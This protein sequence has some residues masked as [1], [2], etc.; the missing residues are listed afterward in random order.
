MD[1]TLVLGAAAAVNRFVAFVKVYVD[2]LGL[3]DKTRDAVLVLIAV[4]AG[5]LIA[6][7]APAI[8]IFTNIPTLPL[9]AGQI[10]TGAIAG[11]GADFLNGVL[12]LLYWQT[13]PAN[14]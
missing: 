4:L 12:G 14:K 1:F 5:I 2:K 9:L 6:L 8:N 11:L 10:L 13:P 7:M 3:E